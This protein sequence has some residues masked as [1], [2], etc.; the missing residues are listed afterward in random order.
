MIFHFIPLKIASK[1]DI[2]AQKCE[3]ELFLLMNLIFFIITQHIIELAN[4]NVRG[5]LLEDPTL[6]G[7]L[8]LPLWYIRLVFSALLSFVRF[9]LTH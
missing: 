5:N 7:S 9:D 3:W 1:R 4:T 8:L 6:L 2:L